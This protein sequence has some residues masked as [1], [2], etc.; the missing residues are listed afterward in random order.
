MGTDIET[1]VFS[2]DSL[3]D[4]WASILELPVSM[5]LLYRQVG[6]PSLFILIPT[7][8][9]CIS[10]LCLTIVL[11]VLSAHVFDSHDRLRRAHLARH[12]PCTGVVERSCTAASGYD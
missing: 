8:R 1:L 3:H 9:K 7:L 11:Y 4:V 12:G 2:G 5:Y 10:R 6:I